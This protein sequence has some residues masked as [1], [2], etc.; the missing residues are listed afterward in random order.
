MSFYE[1][2]AAETAGRPLL[3]CLE[4]EQ[5]PDDRKVRVLRRADV[6]VAFEDAHDALLVRRG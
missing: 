1:Q 5:Q 4:I 3:Q 6:D 2:L